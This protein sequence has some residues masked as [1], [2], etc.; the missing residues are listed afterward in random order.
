MVEMAK[1]LR[2]LCTASI[3]AVARGLDTQT[4]QPSQLPVVD[5]GYGIYQA[6][7]NVRQ[8]STSSKSASLTELTVHREL[9][10]LLQHTL[11]RASCR[12]AALR[13]ISAA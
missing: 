4:S 11:C 3:W 13:C 1:I 6:S 9:L 10:Q 5:L 8:K 2:I 12:S 7:F